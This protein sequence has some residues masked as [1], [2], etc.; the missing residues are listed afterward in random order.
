MFVFGVF[1]LFLGKFLRFWENFWGFFKAKKTEVISMKKKNYKGKCQK[2]KVEKCAETF[3]A[4]NDIQYAYVN[5]LEQDDN[6][7]EISCNVFLKELKEG[8]YTSDFVCIKSN[9]KL[10]VR[11]CVQRIH[12]T[13][14]MTI[15]LLDLSREYW[16]K[17][18][19]T[20]W[21]LV[22]DEE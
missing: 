13:K 15:K 6:I 5:K 14:P 10:M 8:E 17:K 1:I 2:R 7:K 20:D 19:V 11:E 3:R 18:G 21:G 4:Y 12:L 9:N 16:L 22:I